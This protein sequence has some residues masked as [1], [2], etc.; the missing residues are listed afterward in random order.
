MKASQ[1]K[2][3]K[4]DQKDRTEFVEKGSSKNKKIKYIDHTCGGIGKFVK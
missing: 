3:E 2:Y 4:E 1:K